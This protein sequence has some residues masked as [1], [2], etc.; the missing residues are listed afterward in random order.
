MWFQRTSNWEW[1]LEEKEQRTDASTSC[2]R[3][4]P[5]TGHSKIIAP[6][7]L[8]DLWPVHKTCQGILSSSGGFKHANKFFDL[9][10]LPLGLGGL[11]ICLKP[12]KCKKIDYKSF[13]AGL[14]TTTPLPPFL[15]GHSNLGFFGI[16]SFHV[17]NLTLLPHCEEA[18]VMCSGQ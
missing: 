2:W 12:I 16:L 6:S 11:V 3:A 18:Q 1:W 17:R 14:L 9:C 4:T 5:P 10:P 7:P 13:E 15:L 8:P